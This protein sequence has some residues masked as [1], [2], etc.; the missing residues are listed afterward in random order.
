MIDWVQSLTKN[1]GII[2]AASVEHVVFPFPNIF[3]PCFK[4]YPLTESFSQI[5]FEL[6]FIPDM[7]KYFESLTISF[8]VFPLSLVELVGDEVAHSAKALQTMIFE[9]SLIDETH[10]AE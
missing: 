1:Y 7:A 9:F 5:L 2:M 6:A 3:L 4:V 8:A 10:F